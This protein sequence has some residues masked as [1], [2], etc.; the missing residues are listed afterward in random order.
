[1]T[2]NIW[3][4]LPLNDL[5]EHVQETE[6]IIQS[7]QMCLCECNPTHEYTNNHILVIHN[8]FDG[9]EGIEWASEIL[10]R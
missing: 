4:V 6:V 3:H 7:R 8:S 2:N 5:R 1:M 10:K 9:R